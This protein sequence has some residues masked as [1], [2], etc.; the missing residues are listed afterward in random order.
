MTVKKVGNEMKVRIGI[1]P[2]IGITG[3]HIVSDDLL[4]TIR[5]KNIA[6]CICPRYKHRFVLELGCCCICNL[7]RYYDVYYHCIFPYPHWGCVLPIYGIS[8][9]CLDL[10]VQHPL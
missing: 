2:W 3:E 4:C 7:G 6:T 9:L 5:Q 8:K 10:E 1:D